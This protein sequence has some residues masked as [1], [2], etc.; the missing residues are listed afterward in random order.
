MNI[1]ISLIPLLILSVFTVLTLEAAKPSS[2]NSPTKVNRSTKLDSKVVTPVA[3][4]PAT[5][6]ETLDYQALIKK[7]APRLP[8]KASG[9]DVVN[10]G[11]S[12]CNSPLFDATGKRLS[13][14]MPA[15]SLFEQIGTSFAKNGE[16]L[17]KIRYWRG[18][19]W[20]SPC[21]VSAYNLFRFEG[22]REGID[23]DGISELCRY[24]TL[25]SAL[26][27]R[28]GELSQAKYASNPFYEEFKCL[29]T[30]YNAMSAKV[31]ELTNLRDSQKGANRA[32]TADE[33][34]KYEVRE[35]R[36]AQELKK[37][38]ID[39]DAWNAEHASAD[40]PTDSDPISQSLQ[41]EIDALKPRLEGF[42]I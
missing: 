28:R 26:E 7:S 13:E 30:E 14:K 3:V 38:K 22:T 23:Q 31:A 8:L 19:A 35:T 17:A 33:L 29:A 39:Y 27:T 21:L 24:F 40:V 5:P 32:K 6:I 42:G 1:R 41:R 12:V 11:V 20:S 16:E 37:I 4:T 18:L 34:R 9:Q 2:R 15:G 10:W 36:A 25:L